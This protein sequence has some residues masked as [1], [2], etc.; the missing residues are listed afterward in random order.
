MTAAIASTPIRGNDPGSGGALAATLAL[1]A[2]LPALAVAGPSPADRAIADAEQHARGDRPD[3]WVD[4]AAAFMRKARESGDPGYYARASAALNRALAI[5]PD[6]YQALRTRPWVLL[7]QHDF[8][9]AL[10]AAEQARA[11]HPEDW[12]NY[13]N[14]TDAYVELGDYARAEEASQRMLDL[15]P[16]LPAYTRAAFLRTLFGDR[17]GAVEMLLRAVRAGSPRDPE[18]LAWTLVHLGHEYFA[19][20]DLASAGRAYGRALTVL[21]GYYMA[22]GA[23]GRAQ[24]AAGRT[25]EAIDL[26]QRAVAQVPAPDLV[27]ALGDLHALAGNADEA[28]RQYALVEYMGRVAEAAGTT[29]NG[30][31]LAVFYADHDRRL[32]DALRLARQ[33]ATARGDIYTDDALAWAL[34]KNGR[35]RSAM[36]AAHRALRLGTDDALLHYHA[37]MIAVAAGRPRSATRHL[38]RALALNPYFDLRQAPL[39]RAA[40]ARLAPADR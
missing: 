12:W 26:Y 39:A 14:L 22:L 36:R 7:G 15:R 38:G 2:L 31:Q 11:R 24:A 28:E 27:A 17:A 23:L 30:R 34:Y 13:G 3:G 32:P 4:L 16:G 1:A 35:Q 25:V 29:A 21:P 20:G 8:R 33:E 19:A 18:S 40:L 10:A 5:A 6:D 37:G 9:G